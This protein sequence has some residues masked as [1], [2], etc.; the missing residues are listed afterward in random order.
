MFRTRWAQ[1]EPT[2]TYAILAITAA[3]FFFTFLGLG[4]QSGL[5]FVWPLTPLWLPTLQLWRPFTFPFIHF[6]VLSAFFDCLMLYFFG[7]PLER[8]WG[9]LKF[10]TFFFSCGIVAGLAVLALAPFGVVGELAGLGPIFVGLSVGYAALNPYAVILLFFVLPVQSRWIGVIGMA[11]EL[12]LGF[13]R[14]GGPVPALFAVALTGA[15][16]YAFA[17]GWGVFGS[18]GLPRTFDLRNRFERWRQ[19]QRMRAWQRKISK[20]DRP[21]DLFKK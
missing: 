11:L 12:F 14:Y 1:G 17:S 21:D 16:A 5:L 15:Y 8:A 3:Y 10:L 2:A 7:A 9:T 4:A 6:D 18:S 20:I 13:H 19:R